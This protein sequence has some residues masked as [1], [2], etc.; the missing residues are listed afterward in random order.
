MRFIG[1]YQFSA[2]GANNRPSLVICH[3]LTFRGIEK[4]IAGPNR[5]FP[6]IFIDKIALSVSIVK[7]AQFRFKENLD[8]YELLCY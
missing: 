2:V 5:I 3:D 8:S 7:N 4:I 1:A 6:E